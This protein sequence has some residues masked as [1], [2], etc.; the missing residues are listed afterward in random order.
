MSVTIRLAK[1]GKKHSPSYRIVVATTRS[2]RNGKFL[3]TIGH[4]NPSENPPKFAYDKKK[5]NKWKSTGALITEAVDKLVK[6]KYEFKPYKPTVEEDKKG[7][8][9]PGSAWQEKVEVQEKKGNEKEKE[10]T[11]KEKPAK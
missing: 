9:T 6:G 2:K 10:I 7:D 3:D 11:E 8:I 5:F 4:Y 1:F